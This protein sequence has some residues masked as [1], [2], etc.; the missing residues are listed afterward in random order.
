MGGQLSRLLIVD[1]GAMN[2]LRFVVNFLDEDESRIPCRLLPIADDSFG[3]LICLSIQ[4][5]DYGKDSI[6]KAK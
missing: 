4:D 1:K 2:H 3:N 5:E 6:S